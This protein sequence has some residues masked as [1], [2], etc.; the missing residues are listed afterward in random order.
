[1][2]AVSICEGA[3]YRPIVVANKKKKKNVPANCPTQP[4]WCGDEERT[5]AGPNSMWPVRENTGKFID[6]Y[7]R[8]AGGPSQMT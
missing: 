8:L 3:Q 1:M 4:G 7:I 2:S 5:T 6:I